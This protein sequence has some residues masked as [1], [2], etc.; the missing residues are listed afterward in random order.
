MYKQ[1]FLSPSKVLY[2]F[3]ILKGKT[4]HTRVIVH[5]FIESNYTMAQ[6]YFKSYMN[7]EETGLEY[8]LYKIGEI[9]KDNT[10][11][12]MKVFITGGYEIKKYNKED[13][14]REKQR[15]IQKNLKK[16]KEKI[17]KCKGKNLTEQIEILFEGKKI[18]ER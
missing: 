4:E 17:E 10:I 3:G 7:P 6:L 15:E 9:Q 2:L 18:N 8:S 16:N 1:E 5:T 12:P 14:Y 11:K 13:Y